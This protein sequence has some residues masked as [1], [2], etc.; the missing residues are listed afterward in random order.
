VVK[1]AARR[2]VVR[3]TMTTHEFSQRRACGL[4]GMNRSS[5]AYASQKRADTS[6]RE[7]LRE[8]AG[9]RPRYGYRRLHVLMAREGNVLN[10]KRLYRIYREEGL[11]VRRR[12][13]KRIAA[14]ARQPMPT[15]S[16][17]NQRWSMDFTS[18][19]L[20][21]SRPFRTFN[22][23]DD[24][25][26]ECL[27]LEVDTSIPGLRVVRVLERIAQERGLPKAVVIDNGPEFT[28]KALDA[29]AYRHGV[30][31]QFIRPGKP[32]ENAFIESFNGKFRDECLNEHWFTGLNDARFT[33]EAWRRDYNVVRPHSSLGGLTP[34]EFA[35]QAA[36]LRSAPPPS[37]PQLAKRKAND[38]LSL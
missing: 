32:V 7:R 20:A 2:E 24:F 25:S 30:Q 4:I 26:R 17:T 38:G 27:A 16:E 23:V 1:P 35:R 21:D 5:F 18:D 19:T 33:I 15:P 10:H 29:W 36:G 11:A 37:D 14:S 28:G 22:V 6:T 9:Q 12:R 34:A 3:Y 8:L 13:R 31:L